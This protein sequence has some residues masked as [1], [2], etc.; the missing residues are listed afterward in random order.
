[1]KGILGDLGVMKIPLKEGAKPVKQHPYRL[2]PRYK[3]KVRQE[4]DKMITIGIIEPI[5]ESEWGSFQC[6]VM[7]FGL[8]NAPAIF[9]KV[10][11]PVF[12]E[13]IHKFLKVYFDD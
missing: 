13:Y 2:N 6:T 1:M 9:S 11:V 12:K 5:E 10:V 4:L 3:E 7:P 8:K